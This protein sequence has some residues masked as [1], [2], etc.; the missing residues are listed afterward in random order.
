[1]AEI[2]VSTRSDSDRL[3]PTRLRFPADAGRRFLRSCPTQTDSDRFR[4]TRRARRQRLPNQQVEG[5]IPSWRASESCGKTAGSASG[6]ARPQ[7]RFRN[8]LAECCRQLGPTQTDSDQLAAYTEV[9]RSVVLIA[10]GLLVTAGGPSPLLA[11]DRE[12][13]GSRPVASS[14]PVVD[15]A[16]VGRWKGDGVYAG[17]YRSHRLGDTEYE[18]WSVGI[19]R[20]HEWDQRFVD[21]FYLLSASDGNWTLESSDGIRRSGQYSVVTND[22]ITWLEVDRRFVRMDRVGGNSASRDTLRDGAP[23]PFESSNVPGLIRLASDPTPGYRQ[24]ALF[25]LSA[26]AGKK[27]EAALGALD[28]FMVALGEEMPGIGSLAADALGDLGPSARGAVPALARAVRSKNAAVRE[29]SARALGKIASEPDLTIPVLSAMVADEDEPT[30]VAAVAAL[31]KF[32]GRTAGVLGTALADPSPSVSLCAIEA[33][34]KLGPGAEKAVPAVLVALREGTSS[35]R[36][37]AVETIAAISPSPRAAVPALIQALEDSSPDVAGAAAQALSSF[38]EERTQSVA[39]IIKLLDHWRS[40]MWSLR[41]RFIDSL[42]AFGPAATAAVPTLTKLIED[43]SEPPSLR[44]AAEAARDRIAGTGLSTRATPLHPAGGPETLPVAAT[45]RLMTPFA[46]KAVEA[47]ISKSELVRSFL[48]MFPDSEVSVSYWLGRNGGQ[49][50]NLHALA[51][52]RYEVTLQLWF[53]KNEGTNPEIH[54]WPPAFTVV[55]RTQVVVDDQGRAAAISYR[56]D[57]DVDEH[58]D[59]SAW[60]RFVR[61]NGDWAALGIREVNKMPAPTVPS[62]EGSESR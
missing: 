12:L 36:L 17:L 57:P 1:M 22:Q 46:K 59:E 10:T 53:F 44:Q 41:R 16:I 56:A 19:A 18:I 58:P 30:R 52:A 38:P 31:G 4:P 42:G 25:H 26:L 29:K 55:E 28:V 60:W 35:V 11:Q 7:G 15:P 54:S 47:L 13:L 43:P 33:L 49:Q 6:A 9:V 23:P 50:L 21:R 8:R 61:G 24:L 45:C 5:S 32:G 34:K 48:S 3:G 27:P 51:F 40:S 14:R 39:A 37:A 20:L 2:L 62:R